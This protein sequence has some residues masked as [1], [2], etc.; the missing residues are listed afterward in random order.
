MTLNVECCHFLIGN[1]DALGIGVGVE[2]AAD[3]ET[4]V[5]RCVS[6]PELCVCAYMGSRSA[7]GYERTHETSC[8]YLSV[9]QYKRAL[10][11]SPKI[12]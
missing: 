8:A 5:C 9:Y 12:D 10:A 4:S 7:H 3:F 11:Q 1:L 2:F 6:D